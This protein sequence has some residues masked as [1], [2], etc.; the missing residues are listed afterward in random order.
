M[1]KILVVEDDENIRNGIAETLVSENY[2]VSA[3]ADGEEALKK[4]MS[5]KPDL[6]L[7][8]I[9]MP[10]KS[11][12]DVCREIRSSGSTVPVI[13]LSAKSEEIDKVLGLELGADDYVTKPFGVRELLARVAAALRR[14]SPRTESSDESKSGFAIGKAFVDT[15]QYTIMSDKGVKSS[16]SDLEMKLLRY[17]AEHP[18]EVL[19]RDAI[20]NAVWGVNYYGSTRTLDQH[21][22]Q[23]RKK[24]GKVR[25]IETVHGIGYRVSVSAR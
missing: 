15:K 7:L 3:A 11:G 21:V 16:L 22:A 19:T 8:D 10:K 18:G 13:M 14:A 6:V 12:Y 17:F 25:I 20:L 24:L 4:F 5:A 9:M 23:I 1:K 2:A